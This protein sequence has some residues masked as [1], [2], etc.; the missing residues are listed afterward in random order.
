M[1]IQIDFDS[2]PTG[3]IQADIICDWL[4]ELITGDDITPLRH[5]DRLS[6]IKEVK[7]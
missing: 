5:A 6:V 1:K 7:Q 2:I 4:N 3:S